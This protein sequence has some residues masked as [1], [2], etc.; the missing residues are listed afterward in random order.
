ML[1]NTGYD[2]LKDV[3]LRY[4]GKHSL[5]FFFLLVFERCLEPLLNAFPSVLH[6]GFPFG[7]KQRAFTGNSQGGLI[8]DVF[9]SGG[10]NQACSNQTKNFLLRLRQLCNVQRLHLS[11]GKDGMVIR[12]LCVIADTVNVGS[13][14]NS[15]KQRQFPA[16]DADNL[17]DCP[18]HV[19][20]DELA[21]S[22]R[23]GQQ[24]LFIEGLNQIKRLLGGK[25]EIAVCF[26]LQGG[27]IIELRWVYCLSLLL[28]RRNGGLL[29]IAS[30]RNP[31]CFVF[32]FDLF[33]AGFQA[34]FL[35][36]DIEILLLTESGNLSVALDQHG[37]RRGL[38]TPDHQLFVIQSGKKP[39]PIDS[40][41]PVCL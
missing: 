25:R 12:N 39:R 14:R 10:T 6:N 30:P 5:R 32:G 41:N 2:I 27:Q 29:F 36:M 38:D 31:L 16:K 3:A 24:L 37:K 17:S 13:I 11:R 15:I 22:S 33:Q 26:P 21:V 19:I 18:F 4:F 28:E 35:N 8:I 9:F 23:I 40:D 1:G 7:C 34:I 20:G